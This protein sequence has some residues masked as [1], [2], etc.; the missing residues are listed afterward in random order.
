MTKAFQCE[1]LLAYAINGE[2][3]AVELGSPCANAAETNSRAEVNS[4][5]PSNSRDAGLFG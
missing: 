1:V 2:P 4:R 5:N 3:L